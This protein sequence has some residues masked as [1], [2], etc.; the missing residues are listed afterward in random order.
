MLSTAVVIQSERTRNEAIELPVDNDANKP[1]IIK[2]PPVV[3]PVPDE[4]IHDKGVKGNI[5]DDGGGVVDNEKDKRKE[6][7]NP[8]EDKPKKDKAEKD[9]KPV[10]PEKPDNPGVNVIDIPPG[11]DDVDKHKPADPDLPDK[12]QQPKQKEVDS[13]LKE[14]EQPQYE[15]KEDA[16]AGQEKEKQEVKNAEKDNVG[17]DKAKEEDKEV[18]HKRLEKHLEKLSDRLNHLEEENRELREKQEVIEKIQIR[19]EEEEGKGEQGNVLGDKKVAPKE[20]KQNEM[21]QESLKDL[22]KDSNEAAKPAEGKDRQDLDL[23]KQEQA[24]L[25]AL[26]RDD[27]GR[28]KNEQL[29]EPVSYTHLTLPTNREV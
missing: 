9:V 21:N 22:P 5:P 28:G 11:G 26:E 12:Q 27:K 23:E 17:E 20:N 4:N 3:P 25:E 16:A 15:V 10:E 2:L 6:P 8:E 29:V 7:P 24:I 1:D 18:A 13:R 14:R 19:R